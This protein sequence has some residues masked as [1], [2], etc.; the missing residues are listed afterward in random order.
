RR[1]RSRR[2]STSHGRASHAASAMYLRG[3]TAFDAGR[4]VEAI[5]LLSRIAEQDQLPGTLARYYL[6][7]A[8]LQFGLSELRSR[9]YRTAVDH[10]QSASRLNPSS[11]LA[12]FLAAAYLGE[13][14][15]DLAAMEFERQQSCG[16][17]DVTTPIRLAWAQWK[18]GLIPQAVETLQT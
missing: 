6:G 11:D 14:R 9:R 7:Q 4:Y 15:V 8:H 5:A 10:L 18:Q 17:G 3:V 16:A 2:M 1:V 12:G 13:N